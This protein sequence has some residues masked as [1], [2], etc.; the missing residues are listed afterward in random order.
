MGHSS[1][2]TLSFSPQRSNCPNLTNFFLG[3]C[4]VHNI[5][6]WWGWASARAGRCFMQVP[7]RIFE[8]RR[9][10]K[11][12]ERKEGEKGREKRKRGED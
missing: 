6:K 7:E 5:S 9:E 2:V 11:R 3:T 4:A 8:K 1:D 10:K 12:E